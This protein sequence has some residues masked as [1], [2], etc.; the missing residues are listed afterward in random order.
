VGEVGGTVKQFYLADRLDGG[1]DLVNDFRPPRFGE[2]G[3]TF[4]ELSGHIVSWLDSWG[5][6]L[7][8]GVAWW[9]LRGACSVG[10]GFTI[11]DLRLTMLRHGERKTNRQHKLV[12]SIIRV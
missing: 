7:E 11:L 1:N 3:D 2:V 6:W 4:D 9:I 10:S 8:W 12:R 5:S